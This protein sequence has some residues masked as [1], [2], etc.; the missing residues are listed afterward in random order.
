MDSTDQ[1]T[2]EKRRYFRKVI[3]SALVGNMLEF[4]DLFIYG[5]LAVYIAQVFFPSSDPF[6]SLLLTL[7]TF[8]V[9]YFIRP[10]G[11]LFIGSYADRHGRKALSLIHI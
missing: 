7:A 2:P 6:T 9:S 1:M 5:F 11:A 8:G 3:A 4:Y 10:I